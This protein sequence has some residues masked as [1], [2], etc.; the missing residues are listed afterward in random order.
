M[1]VDP[2]LVMRNNGDT[3]GEQT[4]PA[5]E[6]VRTLTG[7]CHQSLVVPYYRTGTARSPEKFPVPTVSTKDRLALLVPYTR[8]GRLRKLDREP[9]TTVA[10]EG[11][12]AVIVSETDIDD[13]LF[14]ML[15]L[16]ENAR[17]MAMYHHLDGETEYLVTGNRREKMA[18]YGNAVTPPA[19]EFIVSRLLEVIA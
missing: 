13:C 18:Q 9:V 8:D 7:K 16:P 17:A 19:T 3:S 14:R 2:A 12:P 5:L 4:T 10:T 1:I 6:P 15:D 11:P